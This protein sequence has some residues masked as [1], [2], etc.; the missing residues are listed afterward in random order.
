M[1][2]TLL[3]FSKR[4]ALPLGVV[5]V[6]AA[7]ALAA[8]ALGAKSLA[9]SVAALAGLFVLCDGGVRAVR[10]LVR[11]GLP[12][13]GM[14]GAML[15]E[16][17]H[18]HLVRWVTGA[19]CLVLVALAFG[20]NMDERL[21]YAERFFI[22]WGQLAVESSLG[23][24]TLVLAAR[25]VSF[26][27]VGKQ[28]HTN[29]AKP[30]SR[31]GYLGGKWLGLML[32]NGVL[33][34]VLGL[35][36][37][38]FTGV[39]ESR[40]LAEST[41]PD[42]TK[43]VEIEATHRTVL[44]ARFQTTPA[45]ENPEA[46]TAYFYERLATM[47]RTGALEAQA[48]VEKAL[49]A[50]KVGGQWPAPESFKTLLTR[51]EYANC[52]ELATGKW[53]TLGA[54]EDAGSSTEPSQVYV[55]S[56]LSAPLARAQAAR[57]RV[58]ERLQ[59]MGLSPE[60]ARTFLHAVLLRQSPMLPDRVKAWYVEKH[61]A[62]QAE[63]AAMT[64]ALQ[65]ERLQLTLK[66]NAGGALPRGNFAELRVEAGGMPLLPLQAQ[67]R[68]ILTKNGLSLMQIA[69]GHRLLLV[70]QSN[71]LEVPADRIDAQ[72]QLK[73]RL[74]KVLVNGSWPQPTLSFDT[75]GGIKLYG[76]AGSFGPNL[77]AAFTL[78]WIK[79][80]FL[81]M[82][83]LVCGALLSFPVACLTAVAIY[84]FASYT[85]GLQES[86]ED[87]VTLGR[88]PSEGLDYYLM[89]FKKITR[90]GMQ[91]ALKAAPD[92]GAYDGRRLMVDGVVVPWALVAQCALVLGL[93]W[94][95]ALTLAGWFFF[96]RREIARVIV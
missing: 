68:Q 8:F 13:F 18:R 50:V 70:D 16:A 10:L 31:L 39:I 72:G 59:A 79:L 29:F 74:T 85:G 93:V 52:M 48:S 56:N 12:I 96:S 73:V 3:S 77:A 55:F 61:P 1:S 87:F 84:A 83:G 75:K 86:F 82:L 33:L 37:A 40:Y 89:W 53:Y 62:H 58:E 81:A 19:V 51:G 27:Y 47:V 78:V 92:F 42:K 26:E 90:H 35:G 80:G 91:Y 21:D 36:I 9:V 63:F 54:L 44:A 34:G 22:E 15:D 2:M 7:V 43:A 41:Q 66:P 57:R 5:A 46:L 24:L 60:E 20:A 45:M 6:C 14:A 17:I 49:E 11:P 71:S 23:V 88:V 65:A 38:V 64:T 95:G 69:L 67:E 32:M 25:S 28:I 76:A 4:Y 30:V 94:T